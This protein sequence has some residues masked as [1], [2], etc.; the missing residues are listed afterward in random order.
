MCYAWEVT[1]GRKVGAGV[2]STTE[3]LG[4]ALTISSERL[5]P[6]NPGFLSQTKI[7]LE[8]A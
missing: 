2:R 8:D 3:F 4:P 5:Q 1:G 6:T 7:G